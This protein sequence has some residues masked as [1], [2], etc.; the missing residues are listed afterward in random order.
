M[1]FNE[2]I[3]FESVSKILESKVKVAQFLFSI[4]LDVRENGQYA[5][6]VDNLYMSI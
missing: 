3:M 6:T 4:Y 2:I 5:V 1:I